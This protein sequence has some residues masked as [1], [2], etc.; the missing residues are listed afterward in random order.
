MLVILLFVY[1]EELAANLILLLDR[2]T[3]GGFLWTGA[4]HR[5]FVF[6]VFNYDHGSSGRI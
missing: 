1:D 2:E 3:V 5:V 4:S 6:L